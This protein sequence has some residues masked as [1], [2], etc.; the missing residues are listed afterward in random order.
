MAR[1]AG[2][3]RW[4]GTAGK[5]GAAGVA[6]TAAVGVGALGVGAALGPDGSVGGVLEDGMRAAGEPAAR[7]NIAIKFE[8]IWATVEQI[9]KAIA[10]ATG[11]GLGGGIMNYARQMQGLEPI[12][13]NAEGKIDLAQID[14]I[15]NSA[16]PASGG[17]GEGPQQDGGISGTDL[18]LTGGASALAAGGTVLAANAMRTT[19][20]LPSLGGRFTR[21]AVVAATLGAGT[22]GAT[23][24][25]AEE[26]PTSGTPIAAGA[27]QAELTGSAAAD[28]LVASIPPTDVSEI[29][30]NNGFFYNA[31]QTAAAFGT[32][33]VS[34]VASIPEGLYDGLD[35]L[36]GDRLPGDA[37]ENSTSAAIISGAEYIGV[38]VENNQGALAVGEIASIAI[39]VAGVAGAFAKSTG[40]VRAIA[41]AERTSDT[42][43]VVQLG[44]AVAPRLGL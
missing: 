18:A 19:S 31:F 22:L 28:T 26:A 29:A 42:I 44:S 17:P 4:A 25:L 13:R 20:G 33:V 1:F 15:H 23:A 5:A 21:A 12:G 11:G 27:G 24:A 2:L 10:V 6:G 38:D 32:G 43:G 7:A 8:G 30:E 14:S 3:S 41:A 9:F 16:A 39:P 34:G 40:A 35:Y 37:Y 36:T